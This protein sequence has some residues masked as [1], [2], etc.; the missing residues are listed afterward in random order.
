MPLVPDLITFRLKFPVF[1][2]VG[3]PEILFYL[4]QYN[5]ELTPLYWGDC[6]GEAVLLLTAH[7]IALS[8]NSQANA[9]I[10]PDGFVV[11][12]SGAG[13]ITQAAAAELS[14]SFAEPAVGSS[15]SAND[16]YYQ[17][18]EYGQK[19]VALKRECLPRGLVAGCGTSDAI[20]DDSGYIPPIDPRIYIVDNDGN[21]ITDNEG[22]YIIANEI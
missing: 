21:R 18:T 22:N 8:Q 15:G 5:S 9:Q 17:K 10:S 7:E 3:N 14:V 6:L 4:N 1:K 2:S 11:T 20:S 19:Y 13:A 16:A 12:S